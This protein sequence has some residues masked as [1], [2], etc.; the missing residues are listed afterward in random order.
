MSEQNFPRI[1]SATYRLQFHA[2]FTVRDALE[3]LDYLSDLGISDVYSSPYF[4]ASPTSTHGYD[5]ADHNRLNPAVG[6]ASDFHAFSQG[7]KER[8]M[9]QVLDFVPNHMGIGESLNTWW[10]ETLEDGIAS[11]YARYFD[12]DWQSGKEA[13]ADRVLLPILGDRYGR[14]LENDDF[15]LVFQ[16]GAFVLNYYETRLPIN[17]RTYPLILR[18]TLASLE[19]EELDMM[20]DV[21]ASFGALGR[22]T[23]EPDAKQKAKSRLAEIAVRPRIRHAIDLALKSFAGTKGD[24][25]SFDAL[26]ELLEGQY[27]RLSYWRVA[28]EEI[29]YRRFFDINTLAAIRIEIPEVFEAA[30]KLVFELL[31]RGAVTGLRID[32]IDGLWNPRQYVQ[33]LQDRVAKMAGTST[34]KPL[35]LV[36]E[37]ILEV[38]RE[39]LPADWPVHGTTGYEFANQAVQVLVDGRNH[40][41]FDRL[42]SRFIDEDLIYAD[43]VYAKKKLT[44]DILLRSEVSALGRR[45][46]ELSELHRDFRDLTQNTLTSAVEEVIACFPVYRTYVSEDGVVSPLDEKVI[47]RAIVAARRRN[48]TIEKAV[49]DFLR[50][51]LLLKLPDRLTEEQRKAHVDFVMRFQQCSGPVMAKGLEDTTFYIYNRLVALNEVGGNPGMFGISIEE[52]HRLNQERAER[53]P[54]CMLATSTHDTKRSED[55]RMRLVALSEIPEDWNSAIRAW[56]RMNRKHRTKIDDLIAPSPNEEYLLYQALAG[57]WPIGE[58]DDVLRESIVAR[59]QEYM[60]KAL[61][62][63]KVNSSWTEPN[64]AWEEAVMKFIDA[65]L[66]AERSQEFLSSFSAFT[67]RLARLGAW[68]SLV[69]TVLKCTCPGVPD[70][71]QGTELLDLSL[72]DPDNRRPVDYGLRRKLLDEVSSECPRN[73][74]SHVEDGRMKLFAIR[75]LLRFRRDH[76]RLFG[77]GDYQPLEVDGPLSHRVIAYQR[78]SSDGILVVCVPRFFAGLGETPW[79]EIWKGTTVKGLSLG[80]WCNL[81]TEAAM[82]TD[83]KLDLAMAFSDMPGAVLWQPTES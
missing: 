23:D 8:S 35:Y 17:P 12:I 41:A 58:V 66:D 34:D 19:G 54:H 30:H 38:A 40:K 77:D 9:G 74:L 50:G 25:A 57:I 4:Q 53:W 33:R 48:P 63:A 32:H 18:A 70:F 56:S 65:I 49:F 37:K 69:Q 46:N 5:V 47:L 75:S 15:H 39:E 11:P 3:I 43:L 21:I 13:L 2:G 83:G 51:V 22:V 71:Y 42:Y 60:T 28:A 55:T 52:F 79:G 61:K 76:Q 64:A 1:P 16:D 78:T 59:V 10:L 44:M 7:L 20:R 29:N 6:D 67:A 27:Y 72:V 73:L 36:V 68:N 14:V 80:T 26:H 62:E 82:E 81:L 31:A 45:L 24:P